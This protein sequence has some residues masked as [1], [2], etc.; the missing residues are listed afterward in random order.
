MNEVPCSM[1]KEGLFGEFDCQ[2]QCGAVLYLSSDY[3]FNEHDSILSLIPYMV[4]DFKIVNIERNETTEVC[5]VTN[6]LVLHCDDLPIVGSLVVTLDTKPF[7]HYYVPREWFGCGQGD[8][9]I[10]FAS[11]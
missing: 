9:F 1:Y 11:E 2:L 5:Y 7:A 4:E 10:S 3:L 8:K 6:E